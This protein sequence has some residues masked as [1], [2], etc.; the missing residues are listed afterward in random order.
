MGIPHLLFLGADHVHYQFAYFVLEFSLHV[1]GASELAKGLDCYCGAGQCQID[2]CYLEVRAFAEIRH[3]CQIVDS[4]VCVHLGFNPHVHY[5]TNLQR[6]RPSDWRFRNFH[7][8]CLLGRS[9][10]HC[11]NER[12]DPQHDDRQ[13]ARDQNAFE[14]VQAAK[15]ASNLPAARDREHQFC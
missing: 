15:P 8:C 11:C 1:L 4:R 7:G 6:P 13:L 12:R 10:V 2:G 5:P 14:I 3:F 9:C